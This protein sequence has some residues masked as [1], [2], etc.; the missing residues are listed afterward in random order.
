MRI[1]IDYTAAVRQRAGIG[2]YTR[3]LVGAL[4][5]LDSPHEYRVFAA[6]GGLSPGTLNLA[7][8]PGVLVR[9]IP[10]TDDWL[11]RLWHRLRLPLPVE[12]MTGPLDLFYSPDFVLPPTRRHTRTLLTVHDL[13]FVHYPEHFVP[14][15]VDYLN[16]VVP[17][18]VA[19]ADMVLA[20]SEATRADL[21]A[22]FGVAADKLVVLYSGVGS[23][24]S[25]RPE[26]DERK[27]LGSRYGL[28]DGPYILAVG[29][30]QPRKNYVRLIDAWAQ[31]PT[32]SSACSV[33]LVIAGSE[34]WLYQEVLDR[35]A[36]HGD[37]V[38][39]L[40][41]VEEADLPALYRQAA[42]FAFPSLYEG[43]GLPVLEAMASGV[44]VVCSSASS[45]PEVTGQAGLLVDPNDTDALAAAL[46]R[47]LDDGVLREQ[48]TEAGL[49]QA[50]RFNWGAAARQL[51]ACFDALGGGNQ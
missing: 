21:M 3:E 7:A 40:G 31:L 35:A 34:G 48:L 29:T 20:D 26:P 18:A 47:V 25:P 17:A 37:R 1:G 50:G 2:R 14:K 11:A 49:V 38:R 8:R 4:L 33:Q 9:T 45:L 23:R 24:F 32:R 46:A 10:L 19:R 27:R 42:V 15:L 12:L 28:G 22:R 30:L 6:T 5:A 44:P 36:K 39:I 16:R 13:S 43:F 41:F 51:L